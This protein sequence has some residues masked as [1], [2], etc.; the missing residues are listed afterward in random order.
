MS[1]KCD[2]CL[3]TYKDVQEGAMMPRRCDWYEVC[4]F[5][6]ISAIQ[7]EQAQEREQR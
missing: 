5:E 2:K 1:K 3:W 7:R 4:I 6:P